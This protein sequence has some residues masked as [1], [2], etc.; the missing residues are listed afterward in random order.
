MQRPTVNDH[1]VPAAITMA[2]AACLPPSFGNLSFTIPD[3][4]KPCLRRIPAYSGRGFLAV[5]CLS[6]HLSGL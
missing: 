4:S 2:R 5:P 3:E 1:A 6:V